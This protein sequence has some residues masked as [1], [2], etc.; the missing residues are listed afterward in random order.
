MKTIQI[1]GPSEI[2]RHRNEK[3]KGPYSPFPSPVI[4][5][6]LINL[7]DSKHVCS[8]CAQAVDVDT[9]STDKP[10]AKYKKL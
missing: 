7:E 5:E 3:G 1:L 6:E 2:P 9:Q 10:V 8:A 4:T